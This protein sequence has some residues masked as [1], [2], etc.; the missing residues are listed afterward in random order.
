MKTLQQLTLIVH[1]AAGFTAL[2]VGLVPMFAK[3][4]GKA[5]TVAGKVFFWAMMAVSASAV[6]TFFIKPYASSRLFLMFIGI[7][8]FYLAYTGVA[9]IRYKKKT[10]PV[11]LADRLLSGIGMAAGVAMLGLSGWF[12]TAKEPNVFYGVLY[13]VFGAFQARI[14][15]ADWWRYRQHGQPDS[16]KMAW[17][18]THLSR[19]LSAY[20]ATVTAFCVVNGHYV[21]LPGLVL[22]I[23]PGL[24]GG[25]GISRWIRYYRK[26]LPQPMAHGSN[27]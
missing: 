15:W 2:T 21:P 23:A 8:S 26:R 7:F 19:M 6:L 10:E 5:H 22:W 20:I 12:L 16:K 14:A 9:T 17:F 4:G 11:R 3:K 27:G 1:I 13:A 18:F 24:I 25:I